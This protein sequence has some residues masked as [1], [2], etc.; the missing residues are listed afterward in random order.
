MTVDQ[1]HFHSTLLHTY[2]LIGQLVSS[3]Q[4]SSQIGYC[5]KTPHA[6]HLETDSVICREPLPHKTELTFIIA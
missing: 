2:F 6:F 3:G 1:V 5:D 4:F